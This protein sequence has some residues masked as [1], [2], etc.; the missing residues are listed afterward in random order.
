MKY[1]LYPNLPII[2]CVML[3]KMID[4]ICN[5]EPQV[6]GSLSKVSIAG[7]FAFLQ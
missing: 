6:V 2:K 3:A 5:H 4:G 1:A 7:P